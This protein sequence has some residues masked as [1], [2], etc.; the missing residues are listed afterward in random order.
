MIKKLAERFFRWFCHPDY[1][2]DIHGDL[3]ELYLRKV[4]AKKSGSADWYFAGQVLLLLRPAIIRPFRP[5]SFQ[6]SIDMYRNYL[7][8]GFRNLRKRPAYSLIHVFGLALGLTAFLFINQYT[9]FERSYDRFHPLP[10]QL[11]RLST[12]EMSAGKVKVT[13]AM[14]F[15]IAPQTLQEEK[16]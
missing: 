5:V 7:K 9:S 2:E 16:A 6:N 15:A 8:L 13:D 4:E 1:F 10:D 12:D 14:T 11:Y 3:E